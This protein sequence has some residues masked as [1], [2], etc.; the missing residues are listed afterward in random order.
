MIIDP[1]NDINKVEHSEPIHKS[2]KKNIE[3]EEKEEDKI[4]GKTK[5]ISPDK[6]L[7]DGKSK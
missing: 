1:E 5:H 6:K 2:S 7:S 3:K 4:G